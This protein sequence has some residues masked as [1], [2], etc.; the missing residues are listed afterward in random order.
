MEFTATG[1]KIDTE[2]EVFS[3]LA[4]NANIK[5]TPYLQG[6]TL[7]TD[8]SSAIGRILRV[9]S[10]PIYQNAEILQ[11]FTKQFD[12]SQAENL[13]LDN[14]AYCV[15]REKRKDLSLA[16]G[17]VVVYGDS[18]VTVN[19]GAIVSNSISGDT[20]T[21]QESVTFNQNN[22]CG[23]T[24][25]VSELKDRYTIRY[26]ITGLISQ[27]P[28]VII[29]KS[30]ESTTTAMASRIVDSVNS[31]STTLVATLNNDNTVTIKLSNQA[32]HADF[33]LPD[34]LILTQSYKLVSIKS[35]TYSSVY[36][37]ANT[38]TIKRTS[39]TG[40]RGVYNPY[41][42]D[43]SK[44]VE[45]DADFQE[46]LSFGKS[47]K[48]STWDC[49]YASIY[50]VSGVTFV[51]I[52]ENNESNSVG[53]VTPNGLAISVL[54]GDEDEIG[55]AIFKSVSAGIGTVGT[56]SKT[57]ND[58]NGSGHTVSFSRPDTV[59]IA[60]TMQITQYNSFPQDGKQKIK[61]A[62]VD[63]F[64]TLDVGETVQYSRLY[65]PINTVMGMSVNNL[66][67]GTL[68][69]D[70]GTDNILMSYNQIASLSADNILI[71]GS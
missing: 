51:N 28:T 56:I 52:K 14:L 2:S 38:I 44:G 24:F 32:Y 9:V 40:W 42:V 46:R 58:S 17:S 45:S 8:E 11:S 4:S 35:S 69:G 19:A 20:F 63:Y 22:V 70:M 33:G 50:S 67:V 65:T 1:L 41:P 12:I 49:I 64:N 25:S 61:Q 71:G 10:R 30:G 3:A 48:V 7:K 66:K 31:Q 16:E 34:G 53:G 18:G 55:I 68:D 23:I 13:Q 29:D 15:A 47:T 62:L 43:E 27:N 5:L 59:N 37:R 39:V 54:G 57:V 60:I 6:T 26:S 36:A 21:T